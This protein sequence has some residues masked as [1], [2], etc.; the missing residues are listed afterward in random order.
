M[1]QRTLILA[2][3]LAAF[4]RG[5]PPPISPCDLITYELQRVLRP[6]DPHT[7]PIISDFNYIRDNRSA[8]Y[9][10]FNLKFEG[11]SIVRCSSFHDFGQDRVATLNLKDP[12]WNSI[13]VMLMYTL[14][15]QVLLIK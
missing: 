8:T 12:I 14:I 4:A 1:F 9:D 10:L 5:L 2:A 13:P 15:D 11:F 6:M 3:I 7:F